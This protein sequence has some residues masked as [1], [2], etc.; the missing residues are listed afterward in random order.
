MPTGQQAQPANWVHT[1][2]QL[3]PSDLQMI[4]DISFESEER[5]K[6]DDQCDAGPKGMYQPPRARPTEGRCQSSIQCNGRDSVC[7]LHAYMF[8][9]AYFLMSNQH[10]SKWPI[11]QVGS[12]GKLVSQW[13]MPGKP[14][15]LQQFIHS[16]HKLQ[17]IVSLSLLLLY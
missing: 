14:G 10:I 15:R 2:P 8:G 16:S 4:P 13:T 5:G 3:H 6:L 9:K 1:V 17:H 11:S 12:G 7:V